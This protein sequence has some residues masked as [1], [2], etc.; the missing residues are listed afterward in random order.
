MSLPE[1]PG[2]VIFMDEEQLQTENKTE[3]GKE[4]KKS[5]QPSK[6]LKTLYLTSG[7]AV[8]VAFIVA[9][10]VATAPEI[11]VSGIRKLAF[12]SRVAIRRRPSNDSRPIA[13]TQRGTKL[14]V[15][16]MSDEW[17]KVRIDNA[18][19]GWVRTNSGELRMPPKPRISVRQRAKI[20]AKALID[21]VFR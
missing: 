20:R 8:L 18:I 14:A 21:K 5:K 15:L 13:Y 19:T 11:E 3:K 6:F 10:Y 17:T 9:I 16:E 7:T 4:E 12:D 1:E 2:L